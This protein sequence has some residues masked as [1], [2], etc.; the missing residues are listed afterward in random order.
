M[1]MPI[2]IQEIRKKSAEDL[3][4]ML[5]LAQD[6]VRTLRFKIASKEVKNHQ[7]LR[8]VRRQI[9]RILTILRERAK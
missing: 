4:K 5:A 8:M 7:Q 3:K 6:E 1:N 9:A 2:H